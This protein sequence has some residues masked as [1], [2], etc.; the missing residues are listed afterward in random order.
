[1]TQLGFNRA[2]FE[3]IFGCHMYIKQE[4]PLKWPWWT[5]LAFVGSFIFLVLYVKQAELDA[6]VDRLAKLNAARLANP[7]QNGS[8][9]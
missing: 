6:G 8:K 4:V 3:R 2:Y 1:M 9:H 7:G 5:F